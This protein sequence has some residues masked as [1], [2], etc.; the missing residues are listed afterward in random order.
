MHQ[1]FVRFTASLC[2]ADVLV[3]T[4]LFPGGVVQMVFMPICTSLYAVLQI[5]F[6]LYNTGI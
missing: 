5:S 6:C 3:Q 1:A 2:A 4:D